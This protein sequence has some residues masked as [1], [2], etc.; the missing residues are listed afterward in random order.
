MDGKDS[1]VKESFVAPGSAVCRQHHLAQV[2]PFPQILNSLFQ[3]VT[4]LANMSV[5]EQCA[6]DIIQE[7]GMSFWQCARG[8]DYV[9]VKDHVPL[10]LCEVLCVCTCVPVCLHNYMSACV[11]VCVCVQ[12]GQHVMFL[13]F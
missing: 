11:C 12:L 1:R 4:I 6:S 7:N 2:C 10:C 9:A 3:I 5:L 13:R 8:T